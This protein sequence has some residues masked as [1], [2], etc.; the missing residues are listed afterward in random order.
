MY[1]ALSKVKNTKTPIIAKKLLKSNKAKIESI[2]II[3]S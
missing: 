3:T 2:Q 1:T